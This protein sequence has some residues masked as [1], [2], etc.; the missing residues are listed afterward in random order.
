MVSWFDFALVRRAVF[1]LRLFLPSVS[2]L[3]LGQNPTAMTV[4][5]FVDGFEAISPLLTNTVGYWL[6]F[7][8]L[9]SSVMPTPIS[10]GGG[11]NILGYVTFG[12][13]CTILAAVALTLV[14][15]AATFFPTNSLLRPCLKSRLSQQSLASQCPI[16]LVERWTPGISPHL[17]YE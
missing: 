5:F 1:L 14:C 8:Y 13:L 2:L 10:T 15:S 12:A 11:G 3:A 6:L 9:F 4:T 7:S 16:H 17:L